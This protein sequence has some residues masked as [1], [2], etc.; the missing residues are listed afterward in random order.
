MKKVLI[1]GY[2]DTPLQG[3]ALSVYKKISP[4]CEAQLLCYVSLGKEDG[5]YSFYKAHSNSL[6]KLKYFYFRVTTKLRF[7]N[8]EK[9]KSINTDEYCFF[10]TSLFFGKNARQI[11]KKA[12]FKPDMIIICFHDFFISPKTFYDLYQLTKAQIVVLMCDPNVMTGGCHYPNDCKQ[13][14]SYCKSCPALKNSCV[15]ERLFNEKLKYLKEIPITLVGTSFDLNRAEQS[16]I[17]NNNKKIKWLTLPPIPF[18]KSQQDARRELGLSENDFIILAGSGSL[19]DKRKGFKYTYEALKSFNGEIKE[20]G[21]TF[22]LLGK[23]QG[24]CID[25]GENIKVVRPGFL[26]TEG[27]VTAFY[28]SDVFCSSSVDDTGPYMVVYSLA[29][30]V[31]LVSFPVGQAIDVVLHKKTGYMADYKQSESIKEGLTMF[32]NMSHEEMLQYKNNCKQLCESIRNEK[33]WYE[34]ILDM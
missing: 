1:L 11:L 17:F 28:A 13:Y 23:D 20:K 14:Q 25:F 31:P 3:H 9:K 5:V 30:G 29:C 8:N 22:L 4:K 24:D 2:K 27:L 26:N 32:Y 21:V 33:P 12:K 10:N 16:P 15:V 34:Q 18:E 6:D 7:S 19:Q